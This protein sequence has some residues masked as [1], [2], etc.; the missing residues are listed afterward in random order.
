MSVGIV[1]YLQRRHLPLTLLASLALAPVI[2]GCRDEPRLDGPTAA[3]LTDPS[4]RH[5]IGYSGR[6][7]A[8]YVEVAT[9][10]LG[11]SE[12]QAGDVYRFLDRYKSEGQG[13]LKI[14]A[15]AS[16][17]GHFSVSKSMR[18][19]EELV[20]RSGVPLEAVQRQRTGGKADKFGPAVK[21]SYDRALAVP[22]HCGNWPE[23]L[24]RVDREKLPSENFGCASQRNFA[25]TVA[26][27]RDLQV[28]QEETPRSS[29]RRS[30]TWSKYTGAAPAPA[31]APAS[32]ATGGGT[33]KVQ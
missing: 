31:A 2:A 7:E 15:P 27:A 18:D 22:P 21:L 10:G 9:D 8:L 26:N 33:P 29:E 5:P 19:V 23:D 4:Q 13:P 30:A 12:N 24:G 3:M 1:R 17:R 16:V 28:P 14:A 32:G 6:T 25:L 11:L 20:D